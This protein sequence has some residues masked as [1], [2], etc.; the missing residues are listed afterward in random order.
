MTLNDVA[1][2][3][4]RY[5][6]EVGIFWANYVKEVKIDPHFYDGSAVERI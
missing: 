5:F 6:T 2:V 1:A 3:I 4:L